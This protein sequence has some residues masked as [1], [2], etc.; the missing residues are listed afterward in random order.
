[1]DGRL[2]PISTRARTCYRVPTYIS[3]ATDEKLG[4]RGNRGSGYVKARGPQVDTG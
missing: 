4:L 2:I 1:M 3:F